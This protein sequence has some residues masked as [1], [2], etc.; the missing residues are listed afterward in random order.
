MITTMTNYFATQDSTQ[1]SGFEDYYVE[2]N[3]FLTIFERKFLLKNREKDLRPEYRRRIEIML[4]A[5][6]GYSQAQI[7]SILE[8]SQETARHWI[9]VARIGQSCNWEDSP[10]GRPKT[11]DARYLERLQELV[12]HHPLDYGYSFRVW[13]AEWLSKHLAREFEVKVSDRH[14]SRL[15]KKMGLSTRSK[16]AKPDDRPSQCGDSAIAIRNLHPATTSK[17]SRLWV[18]QPQK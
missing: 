16:T 8:C 3:K 1:S 15:L 2:T 10:I 5:D 4:L 11:I 13:T 12:T 14:I 18:F 17:S 9:M 6:M 7:C